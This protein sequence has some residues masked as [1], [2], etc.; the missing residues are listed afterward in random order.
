MSLTP[1]KTVQSGDPLI[2]FYEQ[3]NSR[4][5]MLKGIRGRV[6]VEN[7][8]LYFYPDAN[9]PGY[10]ADVAQMGGTW[11]RWYI[12]DDIQAQADLA[13]QV[14]L[15]CLVIPLPEPED[16]P[17]FARFVEGMLAQMGLD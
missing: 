9:D 1:H 12:G 4:E 10:L 8:D 6:V 16:V 7:D 2:C 13:R 11:S 14:G 17:E 15:S 5:V 3:L